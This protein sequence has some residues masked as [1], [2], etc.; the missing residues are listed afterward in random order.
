PE[1][2]TW[3]ERLAVFDY[4]YEVNPDIPA[5][6]TEPCFMSNL[7]QVQLLR[8]KYYQKEEARA[9]YF[10]ICDYYYYF[11]SYSSKFRILK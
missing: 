6:L 11:D 5:V 2:E 10:G 4:V 1:T 3:V 7:D 9:I 8:H